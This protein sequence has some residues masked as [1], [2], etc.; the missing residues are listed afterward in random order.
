[1]GDT[2]AGHPCIPVCGA[3]QLAL[4]CSLQPRCC[5]IPGKWTTLI[6]VVWQGINMISTYLYLAFDALF[7][8][9]MTCK[10]VARTEWLQMYCPCTQSLFPTILLLLFGWHTLLLSVLPSSPHVGVRILRAAKI[11]CL[12]RDNLRSLLWL[13]ILCLYIYRKVDVISGI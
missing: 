13:P 4:H 10:M 8:V 6:E 3:E 2:E 1:M 12:G 5:H 11:V 9:E 7:F